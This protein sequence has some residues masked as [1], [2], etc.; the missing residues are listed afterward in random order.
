[1]DTDTKMET[2][3]VT[4]KSAF[5]YSLEICSSNL[6]VIAVLLKAHLPLCLAIS[7]S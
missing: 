5:S 1:M 3:M 4:V 2:E 7:Q 6:E